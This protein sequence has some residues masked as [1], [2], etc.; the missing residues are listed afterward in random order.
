MSQSKISKS[1][2]KTMI[3][4]GQQELLSR[5]I[6]DLKLEIPGT[7]LEVLI[8]KLYQE[9][10]NAG[11]LFKPKTYLAD[12]WGCP[13]GVPVIGIPFYLADP[14]LC[15]LEGE[16]TGIEA[17]NEDD[18]MMC[19]RHEAGHAFNYAYRLFMKPEWRRQ[20]GKFSQPYKEDYK[21]TPFSTKFVRHIPG[22]YAQK[23]PD[24]DFAETFAVWLTPSSNWKR[25]YADTPAMAKLI[26]VDALVQKYGR[27]PPVV[28]DIKLDM[29]VQEMTMTLD[30]WYQNGR[31]AN[32]IGIKLHGALDHDLR[33]LFPAE[34]G[35]PAADFLQVNRQLLIRDIN[36]W[37]GIN[38]PLMSALTDKL[39][40]RVKILGLKIE[41]DQS[42][43]Q[44]LN[45]S[46]FLTTLA[47]NYIYRGQFI[48]T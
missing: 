14:G 41:P 39:L 44:M 28:T 18:V 26:Y 31:D 11:I 2:S 20:F 29:P 43:A 1:S 48:D 10:Q 15:K 38:R 36:R 24:E 21:P 46:V 17:E 12:E 3:G 9:L 32:Q 13:Q 6:S 23:H 34:Q 45:V 8:N 47:M 4:G 37:T 16:L 7:Q 25:Q 5:K 33:R 27:K 22:W 40:E 19:L 35:Q 30:R 42:T